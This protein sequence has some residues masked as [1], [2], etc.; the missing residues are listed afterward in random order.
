MVE[1]HRAVSLGD[2]QSAGQE[3]DRAGP[4]AQ[5][6]VKRQRVDDRSRVVTEISIS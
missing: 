6:A 3:R 1:Q 5:Y 4:L 2:I